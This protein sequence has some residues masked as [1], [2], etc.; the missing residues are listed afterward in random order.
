[1]C[2]KFE[3]VIGELSRLRECYLNKSYLIAGFRVSV[4]L[5]SDVIRLIEAVW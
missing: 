1:M 5:L 3:H 2:E 4:F